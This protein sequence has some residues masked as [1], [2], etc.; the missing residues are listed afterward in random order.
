MYKLLECITEEA[1][2]IKYEEFKM[3]YVDERDVLNYVATGWPGIESQWRGMWPHYNRLYEYGFVNTTNLVEILR[4][5]IKYI[6]L[7]KIMNRKLDT[8]VLALI[9][10]W[11][12][13]LPIFTL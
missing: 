9:G 11:L 3:T 13:S 1:F 12:S 10:E 8:L 5:Y 2:N 4:H 7:R 6:L